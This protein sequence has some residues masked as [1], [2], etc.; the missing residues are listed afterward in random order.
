VLPIGKIAAGPAAAAYYADQVAGDPSGYYAGEGEAAGRW[1]GAGARALDL[2]GEVSREQLDSVLAGAGQRTVRPGAVGGFDLTF[3]APKSVSVLWA[4][5]DP[6]VAEQLRAGH[7]AAVPYPLAHKRPFVGAD[8][9]LVYDA[10]EHSG[11]E[12]EYCLV[13]WASNQL[14]LTHLAAVFLERVT[15]DGDIAAGWVRTS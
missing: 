15:W 10:Q 3:R 8:R 5:G 12:A 7:D 13:A 2:E 1:V 11:L 6:A 14:V 9:R 4:I